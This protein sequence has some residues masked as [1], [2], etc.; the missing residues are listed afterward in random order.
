MFRLN[1]CFWKL[2]T[3]ISF[4]LRVLNYFKRFLKNGLTNTFH[5][6]IMVVL[7]SWRL[8][9]RKTKRQLLVSFDLQSYSDNCL[10]NNIWGKK[11]KFILRRINELCSRVFLLWNCLMRFIAWLFYSHIFLEE[12]GGCF[13]PKPANGPLKKRPKTISHFIN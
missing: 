2:L 7:D 6:K 11:K 1:I 4:F 8:A 9:L 12:N 10:Q 5:Q 3:F 13:S